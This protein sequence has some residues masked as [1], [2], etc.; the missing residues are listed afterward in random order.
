MKF[1]IQEKL[2]QDYQYYVYDLDDVMIGAMAKVLTD[3][4]YHE[5]CHQLHGT[6][7]EFDEVDGECEPD[8]R[9]MTMEDRY[10]FT[11]KSAISRGIFW[12]TLKRLHDDLD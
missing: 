10:R 6:K 4:E 3:E 5:L 9:N 11:I 8:S 1:K 7:S 12:G 2:P